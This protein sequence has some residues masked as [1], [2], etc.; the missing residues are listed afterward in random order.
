MGENMLSQARLCLN[1]LNLFKK[2]KMYVVDLFFRFV[3]I[4]LKVWYGLLIYLNIYFTIN[5]LSKVWF[6][7]VINILFWKRNLWIL[8]HVRDSHSPTDTER[9][10]LQT[11]LS[12]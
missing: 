9:I 12:V 11:G 6:K 4:L 5:L 2:F 7:K 3:L 1:M 8:L 10:T